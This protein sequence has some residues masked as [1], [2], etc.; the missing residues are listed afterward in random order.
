EAEAKRKIIEEQK[1]ID[2]QVEGVLDFLKTEEER[3]ADSYEERRRIIVD[4]SIIAEE[5]KA[6]IVLAL[7]EKLNA[8]LMAM[9]RARQSA[10][11]A[12]YGTLFDSLGG[13]AAQF[14]GE[15]SGIARTMFAV[16][17]GFAIADA[18]VKIQQ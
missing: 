5:E 3:L 16:S 9:E 15:Q 2:E 13:L 4:S 18:I 10:M 12:S 8:D 1:R 11:L 17:K 7:N 14:A 6:A